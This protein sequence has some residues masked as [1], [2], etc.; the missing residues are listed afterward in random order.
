M[1]TAKVYNFIVNFAKEQ[2][3]G[4]NGP[5][6]CLSGGVDSSAVL[7]LLSNAAN[8]DDI[9][10]VMMPYRFNQNLTNAIELAYNFGITSVVKPIKDVVDSLTRSF[11]I[12]EGYV[13]HGNVQARVRMVTAY[14][15][16]NFYGKRVAGT[17]NETETAVGYDTKYGDNAADFGL[18]KVSK[19]GVYRLAFY[20]NETYGCKIPQAIIDKAP[21]ADL[22]E[23]Q[24]DEAELGICYSELDYILEQM[25]LEKHTTSLF[26][27]VIVNRVKADPDKVEKVKA[28]MR[29]SEHKRKMPPMPE[30]PAEML[31]MND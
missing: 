18:L 21:S 8:K 28:L 31:I 11:G 25:F 15:L 13:A 16:A 17:C 10:G 20:H 14:A 3:K 27:D 24:T 19:D 2:L 29:A 6:V 22:Y 7:A 23:G 12:K 30:I 1:Q 9:L 26:K 4:S 5:I